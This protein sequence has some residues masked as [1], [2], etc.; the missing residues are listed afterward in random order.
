V[1]SL[2]AEWGT[3]PV[4]AF[5]D[6]VLAGDLEDQ[7][8]AL[9][10]NYDEDRIAP[11]LRHPAGLVALSDAGAHMDTLCDQGFATYLLGHWVRERGMLSLEEAV[12]LV[13]A[14]PAGRYGLAGRG[15]LDAGLP[16]DLVLFD[17]ATVGTAPTRLVYD[18]PGGQRRLLQAATGIVWVFVNGTAVV[19]DGQPTDRLPGRVLRGGQ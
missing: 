4:D 19:E 1:A 9:V 12:Q 18:L 6:A 10:M 7:W 16:A 15:R 17:P 5:C 8:G 13:T 3:S 11:M 14:K 2:A